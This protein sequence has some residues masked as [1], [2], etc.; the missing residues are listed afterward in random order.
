MM[1]L[2]K[3]ANNIITTQLQHMMDTATKAM[4]LELT[5]LL[6]KLSKVVELQKIQNNSSE[7]DDIAKRI[8]DV[9]RDLASSSQFEPSSTSNSN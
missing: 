3:P 1:E 5:D 9:K 7:I 2:F 8:E 6:D 4:Q